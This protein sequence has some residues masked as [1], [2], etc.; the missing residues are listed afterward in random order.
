MLAH[1]IS[2]VGWQKHVKFFSLVCVKVVKS[3]MDQEAEIMKQS[4]ERREADQAA[5]QE[6]DDEGDSEGPLRTVSSGARGMAGQSYLMLLFRM[7][8]TLQLAYFCT[9][10][11][12]LTLSCLSCFFC[13]LF[14]FCSLQ[15]ARCSWQS[16]SQVEQKLISCSLLQSLRLH[17]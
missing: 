12:V 11:D 9:V 7:P 4:I 5:D 10:L 1:A 17:N 15:H 13:R 3:Q 2:P 14:D 16:N 8:A 6:P